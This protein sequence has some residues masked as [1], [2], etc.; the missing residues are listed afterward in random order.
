MVVRALR[1][2]REAGDL[3]TQ[4]REPQR[5]PRSLEPRVAG[6]QHPAAAGED[7]VRRLPREAGIERKVRN[8]QALDACGVR[9]VGA[10]RNLVEAHQPVFFDIKGTRIAFLAYQ[11]R[12][13]VV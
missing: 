3:R 11:D 4:L 1:R 2:K 8:L 5:E 10:G 13:S 9:Y 6:D 7:V 12:K